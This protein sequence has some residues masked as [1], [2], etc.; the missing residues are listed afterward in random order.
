LRS[1]SSR[2]HEIGRR[3]HRPVRIWARVGGQALVRRSGCPPDPGE[4]LRSQRSPVR[5]AGPVRPPAVLHGRR[6][7]VLLVRG[8]RQPHRSSRRRRRGE[9]G[10]RLAEDDMTLPRIRAVAVIAAAVAVLVGGVWTSTAVGSSTDGRGTFIDD[11][12]SVHEADINGLAAADIT[13]GCNPPDN[14]RYC[15]DRAVSRGEMASFLAR[16]LDLPPGPEGRFTDTANSVHA[17][18]INALA[19]ADITRGCNPPDNTRYCPD[20]PV[21]RGE[22]ASFLVRA[23]DGVDRIENRLSLRN[24][25][26][27]S[28]D[29][30]TCTARVTLAR[31]TDLQIVEGWYQVLPYRPGEEAAF[32]SSSTR[33]DFAWNGEPMDRQSLGIEED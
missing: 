23:L 18:T 8:G 11:D 13:R 4:R 20:Q 15:P 33:V 21:T 26:K 6:P 30:V 1:G 12:G 9:P 25:L 22:M 29:G 5:S 28:K 3:L 17:T 7:S 14:T 2:H 10:T 24:G 19:A 32:K 16:A 27:C 31:G